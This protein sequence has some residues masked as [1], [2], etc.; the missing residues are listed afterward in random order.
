MIRAFL[1]IRVGP[2]IHSA[3]ARLRDELAAIRCDVRWVRVDGLHATLK[4]L[5]SVPPEQLEEIQTALAAVGV[6]HAACEVQVR[7]MGVFPTLRRPRVVWV[8][9]HGER[10]AP[11]ARAVEEAVAPFGFPPEKRAFQPHITLGRV[12]GT[13][14]WTRVEEVLKAHWTDDF[15][16]CWIDEI[17]AYRSDLRSGGAVYTKLWTVLLEAGRGGAPSWH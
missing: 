8:G 2:A 9:L 3:L 6:Q 4:F 1:A 11:L 17:V 16:T 10:L 12:T 5:G 15:G 13:R 14:G 7:G